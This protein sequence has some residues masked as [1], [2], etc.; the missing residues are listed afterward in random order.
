MARNKPRRVV[1]A[2]PVGSKQKRRLN[3]GA[4]AAA[5]AVAAVLLGAA[6][7]AFLPSSP[8][9]PAFAFSARD[10]F[11]EQRSVGF[12]TP[13]QLHVVHN[14]A[15]V[16]PTAARDALHF[17]PTPDFP[18]NSY[19]GFKL[20]SNATEEQPWRCSRVDM[21]ASAADFYDAFI[22][23]R[24]PVILRVPAGAAG[25]DGLRSSHAP[26]APAP[27]HHL[28]WRTDAWT[29]A[30]LVATAGDLPVEVEKVPLDPATEPIARFG[31]DYADVR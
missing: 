10:V 4:V 8:L 17:R 18:L 1:G 20:P 13:E 12:E 25:A 2:P 7:Q 3:L 19:T 22:R 9:G 30:H 23:Q 29:D 5:V 14:A 31:A 16:Q 26:D 28:G 21:P 24:K 6:H 27:F 15:G 11:A